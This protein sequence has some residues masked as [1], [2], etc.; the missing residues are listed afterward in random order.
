MMN[1]RASFAAVDI[2]REMIKRELLD[3]IEDLVEKLV[4]PPPPPTYAAE[5]NLHAMMEFFRR[6]Q[7][8][9]V[10]LA[11]HVAAGKSHDELAQQVGLRVE[12]VRQRWSRCCRAFKE[13]LREVPEVEAWIWAE[14][15]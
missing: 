5:R 11:P 3:P 1:R 12:T 4:P 14:E 6:Q 15:A 9:C 10:E 8:N 2:I 13:Y 7:A